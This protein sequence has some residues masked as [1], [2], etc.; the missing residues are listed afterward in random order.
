MN[1]FTDLTRFPG[2][3]LAVLAVLAMTT[4]FAHAQ[5]LLNVPVTGN[6]DPPPPWAFHILAPNTANVS[7]SAVEFTI[8]FLTSDAFEVNIGTQVGVTKDTVFDLLLGRGGNPVRDASVTVIGAPSQNSATV[9]VEGVEGENPAE[10]DG[11][12]YV[13]ARSE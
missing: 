9:T 1:K 4:T 5:H 11:S 8:K 13:R 7:N 6:I 2:R 3:N 10:E 12:W